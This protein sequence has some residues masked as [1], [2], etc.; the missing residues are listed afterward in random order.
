MMT[1]SWKTGETGSTALAIRDVCGENDIL[2]FRGL[3]KASDFEYVRFSTGLLMDGPGYA[4]VIVENFFTQNS[5]FTFRF[6]D[7]T[8]T[9]P[10]VKALAD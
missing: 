7:K 5:A 10:Q 3:H 9:R 4:D 6:S 8:L 2:D 1:V